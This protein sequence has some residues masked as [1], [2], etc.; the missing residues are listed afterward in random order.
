M[1]FSLPSL[2]LVFCL[3]VLFL[4]LPFSVHHGFEP[5]GNLILTIHPT[6][7][8]GRHLPYSLPSPDVYTHIHS[9]EYISREQL[10]Y[11]N[12]DSEEKS[13][14]IPLFR[15]EKRERETTVTFRNG[16]ESVWSLVHRHR[17][18]VIASHV[19]QHC[20]EQC[21]ALHAQHASKSLYHCL[22]C[23]DLLAD[24]HAI[25]Q[26]VPSTLPGIKHLQSTVTFTRN[27]TDKCFD[28]IPRSPQPPKPQSLSD[29]AMNKL[30]PAQS[31]RPQHCKPQG[32]FN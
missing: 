28:T 29:R 32:I 18:I 24:K 1:S 27:Q 9:T 15:T 10:S 17:A 13:V 26:I 22:Y 3:L 8:C 12:T 16:E 14:S 4:L 20:G 23:H 5:W 19:C 31:A 7:G 11:R 30:S 25:P 2:M 6:R 21:Q